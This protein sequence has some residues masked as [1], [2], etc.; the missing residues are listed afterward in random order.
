M[1]LAGVL[2]RD[3]AA[4]AFLDD[5]VEVEIDPT[6]SPEEAAEIRRAADDWN[7]RAS[8]RIVFV[9]DGEWLI[10]R[11]EVPGGWCGYAQSDRDI[12]RIDPDCGPALVY[13]VALH[14][15][16]HALGLRHTAQGVMD[17]ERR[18]I[19]F[20]DEDMRECRRAGACDD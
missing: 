5:D 4:C 18:T 14:E 20:S 1:L 8:R 19:E 7:A 11:A 17:P 6:F 3:T 12:L 10:M 9:P 13:A 15:L 16:G 2:F